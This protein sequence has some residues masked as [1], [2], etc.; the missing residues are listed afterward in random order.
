MQDYV[1]PTYSVSIDV[2]QQAS[3]VDRTFPVKITA[4]YT[5]GQ[6]VQGVAVVTFS[7]RSFWW[8][9]GRGESAQLFQRTVNI[10][11]ASETF[12]V[13]IIKDLN[14]ENTFAETID[15]DVEFTEELTRKSVQAAATILIVQFS[16]SAV[17]TGDPSFSAD[18]IYDL[19]VSLRKFDGRS[20]N[21]TLIN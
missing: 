9:R 2:P 10:N 19:K 18:T 6:S 20:V 13:D 7:R 17:Y 5:F 4:D 21:N 14:I 8:F 12:D 11:S 15:I 3:V 16:Y 1:L